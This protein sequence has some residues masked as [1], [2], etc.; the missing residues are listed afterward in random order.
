MKEVQQAE[1]LAAIKT[2]QHLGYSYH[3]AEMWKPPIGKKPNFD[4]LDTKGARIA[5][6]EAELEAVG[7]GGVQRLAIA[8]QPCSRSHPHEEMTPMCELRTE[9]ARLTNAL[10]RAEAAALPWPR[11]EVDDL[12]ERLVSSHISSFIAGER[13]SN[14]PEAREFVKSALVEAAGFIRAVL[15]PLHPADGVPAQGGTPGPWRVR[16]RTND[17]GE[18]LDCFVTAPD[19]QGRAYDAHILGDD[20]DSIDLKLA[21]AELVVA[22]VNAFRA[23]ATH[24][25]QQGLEAGSFEQSMSD[26]AHGDAQDA[27]RFRKFAAAMLRQDPAFEEAIEAYPKPGFEIATIDDVRAMIDAGLAAVDAAQAKQGGV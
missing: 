8:P 1:A 10:A 2:L 25:T 7:A 12:L 26:W 19:C 18:V 9:I 3:G 11:A 24:P 4:L 13:G 23:T 22:A 20:Y 5:E 17:V 14:K 6:L 15:H 21:D 27:E 16:K